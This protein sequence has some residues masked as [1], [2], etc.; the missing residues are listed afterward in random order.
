M[1][2]MAVKKKTCPICQKRKIKNSTHKT[3]GNPEC[4]GKY[5]EYKT[6]KRIARQ[7]AAEPF[8]KRWVNSAKRNWGDAKVCVVCGDTLGASLTTHHFDKEKKPDDVV[9]LCGSCHRI[10]DTSN[11]GL[12]EL[13]IRRRRYY[14]YNLKFSQVLNNNYK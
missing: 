12:R 2:N 14:K 9:T 1:M 4:K 10:F 5:G 7:K 11:S 13:R 6:K 3:C 8:I